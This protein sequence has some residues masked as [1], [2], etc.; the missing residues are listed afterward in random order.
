MKVFPKLLRQYQLAL[1]MGVIPLCPLLLHLEASF[2]LFLFSPSYPWP[3]PSFLSFLLFARS[4]STFLSS[5]R[6]S[7]SSSSLPF[8]G[9]KREKNWRKRMASSQSS[10]DS[11][12]GGAKL[13]TTPDSQLASFTFHSQQQAG[14]PLA[15]RSRERS[16]ISMWVS[17]ENPVDHVDHLQTANLKQQRSIPH[18]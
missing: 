12:P 6:S 7:S 2:P 14:S 15:G 9:L 5:Q 4:Q 1:V 10:Q 13:Q 16:A 18:S 8:F 3:S 11:P 17:P